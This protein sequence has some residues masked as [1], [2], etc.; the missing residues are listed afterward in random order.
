MG[1]VGLILLGRDDF[2]QA[3]LVFVFSS[4]I[5]LIVGNQILVS[6]FLLLTLIIDVPIF[7]PS[8]RASYFLAPCY[9]W[10][11]GITLN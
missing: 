1:S 7:Y 11:I 2:Y 5:I 10:S 4:S 8:V 3:F 6:L 9:I